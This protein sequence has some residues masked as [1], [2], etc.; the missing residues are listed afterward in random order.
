MYFMK[1][2]APALTARINRSMQARMEREML[3]GANR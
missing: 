3:A 1:R 2:L